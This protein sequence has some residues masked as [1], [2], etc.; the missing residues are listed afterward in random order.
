MEAA[1]R[2]R[3]GNRYSM[4]VWSAATI[5]PTVLRVLLGS[6]QMIFWRNMGIL[7][8]YGQL[9]FCAVSM[10]L[11]FVRRSP[12]VI[13]F[14]TCFILMDCVAIWAF[15]RFSVWGMLAFC[16]MQGGWLLTVIAYSVIWGAF[17]GEWMIFVV[18]LPMVL[19]VALWG[20]MCKATLVA[21]EWW[22]K[23]YE[24][25]RHELRTAQSQED[26]DMRLAREIADRDRIETLQAIGR[27]T[28]AASH[29]GQPHATPLEAMVELA[30]D[31]PGESR[32]PICMTYRAN[33]CLI[34]C[35]HVFCWKCIVEHYPRN[36]QCPMCRTRVQNSQRTFA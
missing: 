3:G 7:F 11:Y 2:S 22:Q 36:S 32:C 1:A 13:I 14:N 23:N 5:E 31:A 8:A 18:H 15:Q 33:G 17:R 27:A 12:T 30:T 25:R 9:V 34:P 24:P 21:Y 6:Q 35:G 16:G 19:D 26:A 29:A 20:V 10:G 28:A 4:A